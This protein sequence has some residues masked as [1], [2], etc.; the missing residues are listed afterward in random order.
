[1]QGVAG[2]PRSGGAQSATDSI[3]MPD[4]TKLLPV[5]PVRGSN[6]N[7]LHAKSQPH[8]ASNRRRVSGNPETRKNAYGIARDTRRASAGRR[9]RVNR[10]ATKG[11]DGFQTRASRSKKPKQGRRRKQ[12]KRK[13]SQKTPNQAH[14]QQQ[15]TNNNDKEEAEERQQRNPAGES[16]RLHLP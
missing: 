14:R 5:G 10:R 15:Q 16:E 8:P 4:Q 3:S 12:R 2:L 1:M 6:L 13:P 11:R 7:Q 9:T